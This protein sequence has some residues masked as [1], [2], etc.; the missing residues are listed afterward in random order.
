MTGSLFSATALKGRNR[1][2]NIGFDCS[3]GMRDR[4]GFYF[5]GGGGG[6]GGVGSGG[7]SRREGSDSMI[8]ILC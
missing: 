2:F 6:G 4:P 7:K 8:V 3:I 5:L 1:E